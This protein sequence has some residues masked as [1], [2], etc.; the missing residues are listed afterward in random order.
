MSGKRYG[1]RG[2]NLYPIAKEK[3]EKKHPGG[4]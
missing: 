3:W 4:W 1:M 2:G